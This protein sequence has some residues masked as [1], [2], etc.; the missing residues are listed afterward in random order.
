MAYSDC[1]YPQNGTDGTGK[2]ADFG[3]SCAFLIHNSIFGSLNLYL[4]LGFGK[5]VLRR[6]VL[7]MLQRER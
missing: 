1:G 5:L 6:N 4:K 3:S 2:E 7:Q